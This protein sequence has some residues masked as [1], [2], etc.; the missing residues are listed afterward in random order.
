[1]LSYRGVVGRLLLIAFAVALAQSAAFARATSEV[2]YAVAD[3]YSTAIRFVRIDKGCKLLDRDPDA[4]FVTF[5]CKED[6]RLKRGSFEI[7][8]ATVESREGAKVQVALGETSAIDLSGYATIASTMLRIG[9]RLGLQRR[10]KDV[11][12]DPLDYAREHEVAL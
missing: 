7:F 11:T 1:M 3:V 10:P 9:S 6:E 5:E 12:P 4:A 2:P 8:R